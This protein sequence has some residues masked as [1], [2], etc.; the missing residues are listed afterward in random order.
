MKLIK[1]RVN[2]SRMLDNARNTEA[3]VVN[4]V[5]R[6]LPDIRLHNKQCRGNWLVTPRRDLGGR[7][8]ILIETKN[9]FVISLELWGER[10][11]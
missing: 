7:G 11:T 1:L 9:D 5:S 3:S 2:S 6:A 8:E 10:C 4:L